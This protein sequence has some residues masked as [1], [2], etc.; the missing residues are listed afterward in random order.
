MQSCKSQN[1]MNKV[2]LQIIYTGPLTLQWGKLRLK[3]IK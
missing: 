1:D 2:V 3:E